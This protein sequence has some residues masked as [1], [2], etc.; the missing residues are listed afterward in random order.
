MRFNFKVLVLLFMQYHT[1]LVSAA[2]RWQYEKT[3]SNADKAILERVWNELSAIFT[4]A[5]YAAN[6]NGGVMV[7]IYTRYFP[8]GRLQE[9]RIKTLWNQF[10]GN[11]QVHPPA[12]VAGSKTITGISNVNWLRVTIG[13]IVETLSTTQADTDWDSEKRLCYIRLNRRTMRMRYL[14][15]V[16]LNQLKNCATNAFDNITGVLL[17]ELM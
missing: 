5:A 9:K 3:V 6:Q 14:A 13:P 12:G 2:A 8:A 7:S 15:D 1:L 10:A 16:P 4:A 17:H 11:S